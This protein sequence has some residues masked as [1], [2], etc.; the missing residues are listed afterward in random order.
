MNLLPLVANL[1]EIDGAWLAL[2]GTLFGGAGLKL[3]EAYLG[4]GSA[5]STIRRDLVEEVG[6]MQ[7]R[8]DRV[9][10]EVTFWRSRFY[11]EQEYG[12]KLR[13]MLIQ[14]GLEPPERIIHPPVRKNPGH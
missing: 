13:I 8:M 14:E 7:E 9:E 6:K 3:I 1:N 4:R 10:E 5:K 12:A 2:I 11:E